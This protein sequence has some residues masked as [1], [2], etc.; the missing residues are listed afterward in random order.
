MS[1]DG[2]ALTVTQGHPIE[3]MR[4]ESPLTKES[5]NSLFIFSYIRI[6][7]TGQNQTLIG[8]AI[9]LTD[10]I[11]GAELLDKGLELQVP[12]RAHLVGAKQEA[13]TIAVKT[14]RQNTSIS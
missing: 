7:R 13:I 8:R 5:V 10:Y 14:Q 1:E 3:R 2:I 11:E 12:K 6:M 9:S 4:F